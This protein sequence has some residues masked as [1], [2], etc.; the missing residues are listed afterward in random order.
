MKKVGKLFLGLLLGVTFLIA[1]CS[2]GSSNNN[3]ALMAMMSSQS[4]TGTGGNVSADGNS[5][6]EG[7]VG[8][9]S[10][11]ILNAVSLAKTLD[12]ANEKV[13]LFYYRPDK[14][15]SNWGLWLWPDGGDG[16]PGYDD[17]NGKFQKDDSTGLGYLIL[18]SNLLKTATAQLAAINSGANLNFIIRDA[19]WGKD[20]GDDQIMPLSTGVKHY[21]VISG[22][23]NV[24]SLA[25]N[26]SPSFSSAILESTTT[27]KVV[28]GVKYGLKKT[29][30]SNGFTFVANDGTSIPVADCVNYNHKDDRS[31]NFTDSIF[32][33]LSST[34]D[35]SKTW[36]L[37]HDKFGAIS[38][39]TN[40]IIGKALEKIV[41][42][43]SDLGLTLSGNAATFKVWA[44]LASDV[45]LLVYAD[46]S[47]VG[48][49]KA[50]T[51]AAKASG[52]TTEEEL[53]G[54]PAIDPVQMTKDDATGVWSAKLDDGAKFGRPW[55]KAPFPMAANTASRITRRSSK[56]ASILPWSP[57]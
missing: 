2:D 47:K 53:K 44:P 1:G 43:D 33:T 35:T 50:A 20:P 36:T 4:N 12:S 7:Y 10:T 51:V 55:T 52:S 18:D 46:A 30:D 49:F 37:K 45:K 56:P 28:L 26:M 13:I 16:A 23:K 6:D 32:M 42:N 9:F 21:L 34:I 41:Y 11:E 29:A 5:A 31:K 17:T 25:E 40:G 54:T 48:T 57:L 27:L 39:N 24:Y 38:V 19:N 8:S 15:Y 14:S 22:D 3:A